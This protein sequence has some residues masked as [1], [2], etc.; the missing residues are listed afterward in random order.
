MSESGNGHQHNRLNYI[1][2]KK[3]T[4]NK[5]IG[6]RNGYSIISR[7]TMKF[8]V[9][10][11]LSLISKGKQEPHHCNIPEMDEEV[12]LTNCGAFKIFKTEENYI[13]RIHARQCTSR[14]CIINHNF[15]KCKEICNFCRM[16]P[17]INEEG[18]L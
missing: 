5:I 1:I 11:L 16:I 15:I 10:L 18:K 4:A 2:T 8:T 12:K 6:H 3:L 9:L 14:E 13:L 17:R 7:V